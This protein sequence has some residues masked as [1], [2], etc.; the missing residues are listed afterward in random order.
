M[1]Q[2]SKRFRFLQTACTSV[3]IGAATQVNAQA[4]YPSKP[5]RII[6]AYS[7]GGVSDLLARALGERLTRELGQPVIVDN[8]AGAGGLIGTKE[9]IKAPP[10]GYTLCMGS[11]SP[12]ILGPMTMKAANFDAQKDLQPISAIANFPG[13]LA[14]N[15]KLGVKTP[16]EFLRWAKANPGAGYGTSG[17]GTLFYIMGLAIN[18]AHGTKLEPINYKGGSAATIDTVAGNTPIVIDTITSILPHLKDGSLVP[19]ATTGTTRAPGFPNV[20][21][22]SESLLPGFKFDSWQGIFAPAGVPH[23]VVVKLGAAIAK[24]GASPEMRARIATIGGVPVF[25]TPAHFT[26]SIGRDVSKLRSIVSANGI[27]PQ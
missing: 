8:K 16:G 15:A 12:T 27:E 9:C 14:M 1:K 21:T 13:V 19:I 24:A 11:S 5:I 10:D 18:R 20:P 23:D 17:I 26:E 25:D 22:V 2:N 6:V 4:T 3:L 7:A